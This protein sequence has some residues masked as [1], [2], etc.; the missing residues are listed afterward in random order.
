MEFCAGTRGTILAGSR[1]G[2]SHGGGVEASDTGQ[3][4]MEA[5]CYEIETLVGGDNWLRERCGSTGVS[6]SWIRFGKLGVVL[7]SDKFEV[8]AVLTQGSDS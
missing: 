4:L 3:R 1:V 6:M 8:W 7:G 5:M 2:G